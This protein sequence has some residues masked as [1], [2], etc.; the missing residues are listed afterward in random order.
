MSWELCLAKWVSSKK[1]NTLQNKM[2][3]QMLYM[4]KPDICWSCPSNCRKAQSK[5]GAV[6]FSSAGL[7]LSPGSSLW[8]LW[9]KGIRQILKISDSLP[10]ETFRQKW[11]R[12]YGSGWE[13]K[14]VGQTQ[15]N[16]TCTSSVTGSMFGQGV[17][18]L[19]LWRLKEQ[20]RWYK[21]CTSA[22]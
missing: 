16:D 6:T 22:L 3:E 8:D 15:Q 5:L 14:M 12:Y 10:E 18:Q 7:A 17:A 1:T 11:Q 21:S 20:G 4:P 13:A 2:P 19:F 9:C